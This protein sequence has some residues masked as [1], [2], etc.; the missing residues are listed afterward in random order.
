MLEDLQQHRQHI[1]GPNRCQ[2]YS[3]YGDPEHLLPEKSMTEEAGIQFNNAIFNTRATY[4]YRKTHDG[5]DYNYFTNLYYN[6]DE[7]KGSGIEWE[8]FS[9]NCA[10]LV[11]VR[12]LYLAEDAGDDA[13]ATRPTMIPRILMRYGYPGI[14]STS[15]W[16]S[17]LPG[18]FL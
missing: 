11:A 7:E 2:L 6:Y 18:G 4:F 5:I 9:G 10:D 13:E 14:R 3:P 16:A 1:Q 12:E 15:R 8:R 17:G